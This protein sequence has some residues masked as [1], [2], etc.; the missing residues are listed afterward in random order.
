M[1]YKLLLV[2]DDLE[3]LAL[4]RALLS[5][6]GYSVSLASSGD[7]ALQVIQNTKKDFALVLM[8]YH[9]PGI[10]GAQAVIEIKKIR[11][12]QQILAFSLDTTQE[13]MRE[14]YRAGVVDFLSKNSTTV[15]FGA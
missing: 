3:N 7:N 13:L 9:M 4:N 2:D 14:T 6:A 5:G 10:S 12:H 1:N 15:R 11:P 8:D